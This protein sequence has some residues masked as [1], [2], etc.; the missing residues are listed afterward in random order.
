MV[1][2]TLRRTVAVRSTLPAYKY[3][4]IIGYKNAVHLY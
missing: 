1:E 4:G 2:F 3:N